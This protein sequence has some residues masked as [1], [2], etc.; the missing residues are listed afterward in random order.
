AALEDDLNTPQAIAEVNALAA[1]AQKV[2]EGNRSK[3]VGQLAASIDLL[4]LTGD[5]DDWRFGEGQDRGAAIDEAGAAKLLE[6]RQAAKVARDFA[7]ADEIRDK[8]KEGGY[9]VEDTPQGPIL[10]RI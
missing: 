6:D 3:I 5:L 10:R 2:D 4:G 7:K 8:L 1:M 9:L